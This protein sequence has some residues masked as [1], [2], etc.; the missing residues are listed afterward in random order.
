MINELSPHAQIVFKKMCDMVNAPY[1]IVGIDRWFLLYT[2]TPEAEKEFMTWLNN[3]LK[4]SKEAR[5]ELMR[6]PNSKNTEKVVKEFIFQYG[7]KT[8]LK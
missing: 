6:F 3:Y 1:N 2:W 5:K 7:W 8:S 4:S